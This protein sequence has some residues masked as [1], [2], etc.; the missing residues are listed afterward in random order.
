L[1]NQLISQLSVQA[2]D[3]RRQESNLAVTFAPD[4]PER[5]RL[6]S[7]ITEIDK[8]IGQQKDGIAQIVK[9][10]YAAAN[11]REKLLAAQSDQQMKEVENVNEEAIQYNILKREVDT[12]KEIYEGLLT[13]LKEAGVSAGLRA[14][15]VHFVDRAEVPTKPSRPQK[16]QNFLLSLFV[17]LISGVGLAFLQEYMDNTIK[18]PDDVTRFFQ[19]P[20]L[21][22]VPKMSSLA[23]K[24]AYRYGYGHYGDAKVL[25]NAKSDGASQASGQEPL[26]QSRKIDLIIHSEPTSLMAEAYRSL[27]TSLLLSAADHP[28]R[29]V[30]VTSSLPSEGKSATAMNLAVSLTQSGSRTLLIDADMRKPRIHAAL[31]LG[32]ALGLSSF[33][34]GAA[35]LKDV[36]HETAIP[37]L[38]VIPCGAIPPN[39]GELILSSRFARMMELAKE[40]F[41]YVVLDSPPLS[42]VSDGRVL[43]NSCEAVLIVIK[44]ASTS[45]HAVRKAT[46][47]LADSRARLAGAVLNDVDVRKR[48]SDY[49]YYYNKGYYNASTDGGYGSHGRRRT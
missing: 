36:I 31:G 42:H 1:G 43:A 18:S 13:R 41:D 5:Q 6:R 26:G 16:A 25:E 9:S 33:L 2:A 23:G 47:Q 17:G 40:Y 46:E 29:T 49:S 19:I 45:R 3:L 4:W 20:A 7:Q 38:Y 32:N 28:P 39:P 24:R 37:G 22:V 12:N 27:R 14:S 48:N 15:N 44:A 10:E 35:N 34:T 21:A 8:E 30:L 11:D